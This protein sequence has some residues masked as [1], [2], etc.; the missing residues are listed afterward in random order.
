MNELY[1][2]QERLDKLVIKFSFEKLKLGDKIIISDNTENKIYF[3]RQGSMSFKYNGHESRAFKSGE[4][5]FIPQNLDCCAVALTAV[6]MVVL[7]YDTSKCNQDGATIVEKSDNVCHDFNSLEIRGTINDY[8]DLLCNYLN[9]DA[10]CESLQKLK[11]EEL[12]IIMQFYYT[13]E[14]LTCFFTQLI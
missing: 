4:M 11:F 13:K 2:N 10:N 1:A 5:I 9:S 12:L 7:K 6:E 14:E 8:L 3:L